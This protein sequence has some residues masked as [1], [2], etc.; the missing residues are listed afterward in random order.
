MLYAPGLAVGRLFDRGHLRVPV[1]VASAVFVLCMFLTAECTE[2]WQFLLC[3]GVGMGLATGV[4]FDMGN[5]VLAHW[6]KKRLGF[7][8]ACILGGA[9]IGGCI[10]PVTVKA[11]L[12]RT[13]FPW[14]MRILG[15]ITFGL[16]VVTNLTIAR[17]LPGTKD[18]GPLVNVAAFKNP[19]CSFYVASLVVNTL[20]LF[21]VLTYLTVS[22]VDDNLNANLAFDLLTIANATS[23]LG[24]VASGLLADRYGPLN[25]LIPA[26]L[27][28]AV[29]TYAWP[30]A[31]NV[32]AFVMISVLIGISTGAILAIIV[33][34][35]A[36]MGPVEDVGLRI[37]MALTVV[38]AGVI[39]GPPISGAIV[40]DTGS[41]K[42]VGYY[43]GSTLLLSAALMVAARHFVGKTARVSGRA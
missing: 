18:L 19:A 22:A 34:P 36:H 2:Y 28:T 38:T 37:G 11:L 32:P 20:A 43:G 9:S 26:T 8:L 29:V 30:F 1:F 10:F 40:D 25:V 41:F 33:Q 14:T 21:T 16:L 5:M 31:A 27:M 3:Q 17:R 13:S 35:F 15:F 4:V 42:N 6:F 23:T 39:A 24:R 12:Q 7:A